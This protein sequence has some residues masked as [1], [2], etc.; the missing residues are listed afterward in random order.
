MNDIWWQNLV[1]YQIYPRSFKDTNGDGIGDLP[2]IIQKL[3]YLQD[4]GINAIWLC[5]VF[6][7]P[8]ID[9]GYDISNYQVINPEFGTMDDMDTLIGEAKKRDIKVI[10]D[11]VLN[12]T[13][14]RHSWFLSAL[15][16]PESPYRDFYIF[17]TGKNGEAPNNWRSNFGGSAWGRIE[18]SDDYY[19]H[20][21]APGQPDLNWENPV[22]RKTLYRMID[23]WIDK[24]I[25]GFRIDAI[26]YIKKDQS[27]PS[28]PADGP[29]GLADNTPCCLAF[30][31]IEEF[32]AE[33][34]DKTFKPRGVFTV[35]EANGL[36]PA[37]LEDFI[38]KDGF[39]STY[40]DF[41]YADID[42]QEGVWHKRHIF[43]RKELRDRI[44]E[45][46]AAVT[47][48]G[49]HGAPYLENHD[50][51]RSPDKYL[52]FAQQSFE[53]KTMLG[54][55]YFFL[56]GTPF[57][58]QGQELGM[59]NYPWKKLDEFNDV[60]T[61]DQFNRAFEAGYSE[62]EAFS[63]AAYRSRDNARIPFPWSGEPNAGFSDA[64]P[65][66]PVHPGCISLNAENQ[67]EKTGSV[68]NFYKK[69]IRLR[70]KYD[71]LFFYGSFIPQFLYDDV[72]FAYER[73]YKNKKILVVCNF[74]DRNIVLSMPRGKIV[75]GN[76]RAADT[77]LE[78]A[79][80]LVP[81]EA[82]VA[83]L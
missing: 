70:K 5:P 62:Q 48:A 32:L 60:A 15:S 1:V 33:M 41:S 28:L 81:L 50:Q 61:I 4:L 16:D 11:L 43:T 6:E 78:G 37:H 79:Y 44:F 20:I 57:I 13:S 19:L 12:H 54:L 25:A 10:L 27:F 14:D 21:F 36:K 76:C 68:M 59:T 63:I 7:S 49:G 42:I 45:N 74:S 77:P 29:D 18:G 72:I 2:G 40:F 51:P 80:S 53:G 82:F 69:M 52:T 67:K 31:G 35:A 34:R 65:W 55:L 24:G 66:L 39:F 26:T 22:M 75:L 17:R 38:G 8:M 71:K 30:P 64:R 9:N 23:W 47:S 46:Q 58:Y 73:H 56:P 83:E 3:D